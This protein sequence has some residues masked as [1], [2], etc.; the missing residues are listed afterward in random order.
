MKVDLKAKPFYL[1]DQQIAWVKETIEHMPLDDKIGQLFMPMAVMPADEQIAFFE[2]IGIKPCGVL[3]RS[4]PSKAIRETIGKLQKHYDIPLLIAGD[5][6]RGSF[7]MI[8]DGTE[9]GME[10]LV[11]AGDDL[12]MAYKGGK[13]MGEECTAVGAHWNFGPVVDIDMNPFNPITNVRTFGSDPEKVKDFALAA[14]RGMRD[15]GILPCAK[16]FPGDGVDFRDQHFLS[17]V[18][19]L[20]VEEWDKTY[21]MIYQALIDD[22]METI[23]TVHITQPA[24]TKFFSPETEDKDILPASLSKELNIKLLR[25]KMGFNGLLITDASGMSG[26]TDVLPRNIAVPT[27]IASGA[28]IFLFTRDLEEDFESMKEGVKNGILTEE[29]IDE[30]LERI[31]GL[32]AKLHLH[33]KKANGTIIP[34]EEKLAIFG[35]E[36]NQQFAVETARKGITLVKDVNNILPLNPEKQKNLYVIPIVVEPNYHN[37]RTGIFVPRFVKDLEEKGFNVTLY[38]GS[39]EQMQLI[40]KSKI[41]EFKKQYDAIIYFMNVA[42]SNSDSAARISWPG[43]RVTI[44]S[45]IHDVPNIMVSIDNPYHLIDAPRISTLVNCYSSS[46]LVVDELVNKLV[47][48]TPFEGKSPVDA[49]V[50]KYVPFTEY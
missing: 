3:Y 43:T 1:D 13:I 27:S 4:M 50:K 42:T 19:S 48:E 35:K 5:L 8:S 44:T 21:G 12:E 36:E 30:A 34:P 2:K 16:H 18:N 22:G 29:R 25:E 9:Y 20:S 38:D 47:G 15:G 45:M 7:N 14:A 11:A 32:K 17:S 46:P 41:K 37:A 26:F 24:Y 6:D 10:M 23:M 28:D 39:P 40:G 31:L 49:F 33:E